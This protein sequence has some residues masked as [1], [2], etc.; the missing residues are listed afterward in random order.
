MNLDYR[1]ETW[2]R[3][4]KEGLQLPYGAA[5]SW[6]EGLLPLRSPKSC[7]PGAGTWTEA[8]LGDQGLTSPAQ[9]S[10]SSGGR[11]QP[12]HP[13]RITTCSGGKGSCQGRAAAFSSFPR[14]FIP[15]PPLPRVTRR[16]APV[17]IHSV[18]NR[19]SRGEAGEQREGG[20]KGLHPSKAPT[21]KGKCSAQLLRSFTL[22]KQA[23][24][25]RR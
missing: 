16:S 13:C 9:H 25:E 21:Q 17:Q 8:A 14:V 7:K 23:L 22:S 3:M 5:R 15:T 18:S 6:E 19:E 10:P 1:N 2:R 24:A 11:A 4:L 12:Q 20:W